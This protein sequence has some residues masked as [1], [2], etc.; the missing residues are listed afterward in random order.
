MNADAQRGNGTTTGLRDIASRV[1][2]EAGRGPQEMDLALAYDDYPVMVCAQLDDVGLVPGADI[3][4]FLAEQ[5]RDG[6]WPLNTSGGQLSAGQAGAA[7][8]LHGFVEAA[9][10]LRERAG[11]RQVSARTAAITGYGMVLYR[12][13]AVANLTVLAA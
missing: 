3:G 6:N 7:G 11:V 1:W 8:G 2:D 13:G 9:T 10:Q 4:R 5:V 12:Y